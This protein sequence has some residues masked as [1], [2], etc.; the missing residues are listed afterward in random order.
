MTGQR[1]V[2]AQLAR[3]DFTKIL[4]DSVNEALAT[5]L[6]QPITPELNHHLQAYIGLSVDEMTNRI[7]LLFS[8]LKDSFGLQGGSLC[9]LVVRK[10]YQKSGIPFYEIAGTQMIQYVNELKRT[11]AMAKFE[12]E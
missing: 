5:V 6:G 2:N 1:E 12:T 4:V 7:D 10:M 3:T 8:T 11:L 9:K